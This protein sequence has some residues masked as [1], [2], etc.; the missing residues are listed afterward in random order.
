[1]ILTLP[2]PRHAA[3]F[4]LLLGMCALPVKAAPGEG[5]AAWEWLTRMNTTVRTQTYV[6]KA[7]LRSGEQTDTILVAHRF[8]AG[9]E[10]ERVYS[11]SGE[12]REVI[13]ERGEL[14]VILPQQG[15]QIVEADAGRGL[16][17]ILGES[18]RENLQRHYR[19]TLRSDA[20]RVAGR[21]TRKLMIEPRDEWRWGYRIELDADTAMPLLLEVRSMAEEPLEQIQFIEV[22]YPDVLADSQIQSELASSELQTVRAPGAEAIERAR[23]GLLQQWEVAAPPPGFRLSARSWALLPGAAVPVAHW[24]YSDG[25]AS[26]SVY[27]NP[28]SSGVDVPQSSVSS[29]AVSTVRDM[30]EGVMV[31]AMGE[32]PVRTARFFAEGL[33]PAP[34]P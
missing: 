26:I 1:M 6:G 13:R 28:V 34:Q 18:A 30:A 8:E 33:R 3:R 27:A 15:I 32:V 16:L 31:T 22:E 29:G 9:E 10:I 14:R 5:A 7:V 23:A 11:L 12:P 20:G 24:V 21:A 25:L 4:F 2:R 17:P 19:V